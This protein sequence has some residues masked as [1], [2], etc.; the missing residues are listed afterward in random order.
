DITAFYKDINGQ[1]VYAFQPVVAGASVAQY[2]VYENQDFATTKGLEFSL[3]IRRIERVRA[4]INY[5]YSDSRGTNS[6]AASAFGSV[7]VNNAVPTVIIPLDYDQT[8]RGAF[9]I[10]SEEHT[11]ELQSRE[12]LVC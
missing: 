4:E 7:Q 2:P 9:S 3:K 8:H 10:R 11:S 12:N 1:L 6:F 5:T